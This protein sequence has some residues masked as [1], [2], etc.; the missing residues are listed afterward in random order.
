MSQKKALPNWAKAFLINL[1]LAAILFLPF[2]IYN[3][4]YFTFYGDFNVQQIP[5]YRLAHDA[6][7][8]GS[9][10]WNWE[11][12]LG[13]NFIGSYS[14]YLLFSP[15]FWLTLPFPSWMVPYLMGPLLMLKIA[16]MGL[17]AYFYL[18]RFVRDD[19]YAVFGSMLYAFSGFTVYNIF[20]NH[21][22]DVM[23]F[24]PLMLIALE[25]L[26]EHGRK[27]VFA[28]AVFLNAIVNYWFFIGEVV[29]VVL[30]VFIRWLSPG[31][32]MNL[33]KFFLIALES[34][35]GVGL[36]AA[37]LIPSV[38]AILGNPRTTADNLLSG[39]N[40]WFYS[41][42]ERIP[43][44][45]QSFLFPPELP[46]R[47][48]FFPNH[49]AKWS[50]LAAWLPLVSM[51]GVLAFVLTKRRHW[52][53][54]MICV[55]FFMALFPGLNS[56]FIALNNSYYTRWFYMLVL[57]MA[58]ATIIALERREIP[59]GRGFAWTAFLTVF[60][61]AAVGLTPVKTVEEDTATWSLGLEAYPDRFWI[62]SLIA[63]LSLMLTY[64][65]IRRRRSPGFLRSMTVACSF[66]IVTSSLTF[67]GYGMAH[68]NWPS[69][70]IGTG[71]EGRQKLDLPD[72]GFVRSDFYEAMDNMGMFLGLPNIQAFHSIVPVSIM[73]F[74]P[75][76]GVKRDVSSKP[77]ADYYALRSLLSVKWL[78]IPTDEE[79]QSP[80]P[81]YEYYD[82]QDNFNIYE[83]LN[84]LPMG[85]GY[86]LYFTRDQLE[87]TPTD[88]RHL[89]MI[90][91]VMLEE[92][93]IQRNADILEPIQ[94]ITSTNLTYDD[95][96]LDVQDRRSA[97]A[98]NFTVTNTGFTAEANLEEDTLLFFSVPY[99]E[100]WS[101][102]INGEEAVIER[103]N[104]GFMAVRVPAGHS[105][106]TFTYLTPGLVPG[107]MVSLG[108]LILLALYWLICR[109]VSPRARRRGGFTA[110]DLENYKRSRGLGG[111][112]HFDPGTPAG[113]QPAQPG[114]QILIPE[115]LP[116]G[117]FLDYLEEPESPPPEQK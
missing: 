33:K 86:D 6:V 62:Y 30:Y 45:I 84:Y 13:V 72:E 64:L 19:R 52:L 25:E 34:I 107:A 112:L 79:E 97:T 82:T 53:K 113:Q 54:R 41:N 27:G 42:S 22:L 59:L 51:S 17:T 11:T 65:L 114:G 26:V 106:I 81:G 96:E 85:F 67:L 78:F 110:Q 95:Y 2:M 111:Q 99:D 71:I 36:A 48:N 31:W 105:E 23:V 47:P 76:V 5:F 58:L 21:F 87:A 38:L 49:G 83:N 93:A 3:G 40:F 46:S 20:F 108:S 10:L 109:I 12:D 116:Q 15:F 4:G 98:E 14:F 80:M 37:V 61:I 94:R 9:F 68:S 1:L 89:L 63:V 7:R 43:A 8:S 56:I 24:F 35:L 70:I 104:I 18:R 55:L 117:S 29:F 50:S 28:L 69:Y 103:A 60:I 90:R 91:G 74:Y 100:G 102:A 39:W 32:N 73:E 16:C 88:L 115:D 101:A 44:I 66:I 92:D 57:L 77:Q 75:E